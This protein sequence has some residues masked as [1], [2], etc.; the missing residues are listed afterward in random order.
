M[1]VE[2]M[3]LALHHSNASGT[4]KVVLLGIANHDG[5][6]GAW[7]S[8]PTLSVYANVTERNV[9]KAIDGLLA[10]GEIRRFVQAGGLR[11]MA[12]F[13]R[14]NLYHV[15]I[16]CPVNCDRTP[17]HLLTCVICGNAL[18]PLQRRARSLTCHR[19]ECQPDRVSS[20]TPGDVSDTPGGV[21]SDTQTIPQPSTS[22]SN[23]PTQPQNA[24]GA[25][26]RTRSGLHD[27]HPDTGW[28]LNACGARQE[29]HR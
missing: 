1:S 13:D 9:Q 20:A 18:K 29:I 28:C 19:D 22:S 23:Y 11:H 26:C 8:I 7:P 10:A 24:R 25:S 14:P 12:D 5:D 15:A 17:R 6:G 3:A 2:A 21:V 16:Q 27:F 4:A